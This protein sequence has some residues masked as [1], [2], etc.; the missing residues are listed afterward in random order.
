MCIQ[1]DQK[2]TSQTNMVN[3]LYYTFYTIHIIYQERGYL[4]H[5]SD[6]ALQFSFKYKREIDLLR[7]W[8]S[9]D[10]LCFD[11]QEFGGTSGDA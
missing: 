2:T 11:L 9:L 1:K 10:L 3:P 6:M 5:F 4:Y 7:K 8:K